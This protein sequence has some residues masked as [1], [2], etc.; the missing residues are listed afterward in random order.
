MNTKHS[1]IRSG[2]ASKTPNQERLHATAPAGFIT[3]LGDVKIETRTPG[4]DGP[5]DDVKTMERFEHN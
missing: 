5:I 4:G 3:R 2:L 1:E